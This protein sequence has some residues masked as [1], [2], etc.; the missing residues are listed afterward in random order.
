MYFTKKLKNKFIVDKKFDLILKKIGLDPGEIKLSLVGDILNDGQAGDYY[1]FANKNFIIVITQRKVNELSQVSKIENL[2][3][4]KFLFDSKSSSGQEEIVTYQISDISDMRLEKTVSTYQVIAVIDN[5]PVIVCTL[6]PPKKEEFE[7]FIFNIGMIKKN[8]SIQSKKEGDDHAK[9]SRKEKKHNTGRPK[10]KA[11]KEEYKRYMETFVRV[12]SLTKKFY[13]SLI[14]VIVFTIWGTCVSTFM[15]YINGT[16]LYDQILSSSGKYYGNILAFVISLFT[17]TVITGVIG[18]IQNLL[19]AKISIKIVNYLKFKV[20]KAIQD[21]SFRFLDKSDTGGLINTLLGDTGALQGFIQF[22]ILGFILNLINMLAMLVV[23]ICMNWKLTL[24]VVFPILIFFYL[25]K[26]LLPLQWGFLA[27][28][29]RKESILNSIVNNSLNRLKLIRAFG[30]GEKESKTFSM[31]NNELFDTYY[32]R[33]KVASS[34][35]YFSMLALS[36]GG[37]LVWIYGG[38]LVVN[39]EITYGNLVSFTIY[40]VMFNGYMSGVKDFPGQFAGAM[41]SA[42][43][44]FELIDT[45]PEIADSPNPISMP[46]MKGDIELKN[47][48]FG[49]EN[50]RKIIDDVSLHIKPGQM[51]G[52][53][54]KTGAGKTTFIN[55]ISRLYDPTEGEV[56][57]DGVDIKDIKISDVRKNISI[58]LQDTFLFNASVKDNIAFA[59]ENAT[60]E[61]I[62]RAAKIANAHN[63]I[64]ELPEGYDTVL[65]SSGRTLSG[66]QSQRIAIARA[67]LQ[68]PKILILDEATAS[69][70]V[71]TEKSIQEALDRLIEGRTTL[72][73]AHKLYTLKNAN[74]FIILNNGKILECS[75]Y[76][77][78]IGAMSEKVF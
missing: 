36:I 64:M 68:N 19:Y 10:R 15:P 6:S 14:L 29:Y 61:E 46:N 22:G 72:V 5:Q 4:K 70:D 13:K 17:I 27:Q 23:L 75:S 18:S 65:G 20:F 16:V 11:K 37:L 55:V 32:R 3:F 77:K 78:F 8:K 71:K 43:R 26:K 57:L 50:D 63:F 35:Y 34:S 9:K 21:K 33:D 42:Q 60:E 30:Q 67:V 2:D 38:I 76:D 28:I 62:I 56:M 7:N 39:K 25:N 66:G 1:I 73:I 40:A 31:S 74:K 24:L 41:N 59:K 52:I 45:E 12:L 47:V 48:S 49:Y 69:L 44:I 54:G 51:V 53:G 58:V